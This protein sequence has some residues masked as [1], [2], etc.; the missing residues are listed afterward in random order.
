MGWG[1]GDDGRLG[2][3][4]KPA[5][6]PV[7]AGR[8]EIVCRHRAY[9][10]HALY[11]PGV[12]PVAQHEAQA[13]QPQRLAVGQPQGV[14]VGALRHHGAPHGVV[15]AQPEAM[16]HV[17]EGSDAH[18]YMPALRCPLVQQPAYVIVAGMQIDAARAVVGVVERVPPHL[19][20]L[21]GHVD[22]CH[23]HHLVYARVVGEPGDK[24]HLVGAYTVLPEHYSHNPVS[25]LIHRSNTSARACH[26]WRLASMPSRVT[27]ESINF[28]I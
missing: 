27:P 21:G 5:H 15:H 9:R 1:R 4:G 16:E 6:L 26:V 25:F 18:E 22:F 13:V 8:A 12:S 3:V 19:P 2:A 11:M 24:R 23:H 28:P 14:G 17:A 7:L 10:K 20:A